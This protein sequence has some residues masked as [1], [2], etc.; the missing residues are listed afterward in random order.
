[1]TQYTRWHKAQIVNIDK[2]YCGPKKVFF[3]FWVWF[4]PGDIYFLPSRLGFVLGLSVIA[5]SE[6]VVN[7]RTDPMTKLYIITV[8]I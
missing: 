4:K 5:E 8:Y 1:M 7:Y 3:N 2:Y 6:V